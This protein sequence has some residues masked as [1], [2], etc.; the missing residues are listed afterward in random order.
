MMQSSSS[1]S[2]DYLSIDISEDAERNI[3]A[4]D[5]MWTS[6]GGI[7]RCDGFKLVEEDRKARNVYASTS[8][9]LPGGSPVLF[10]PEA[11]ILSSA[12]AMAEL[13]VLP[14]MEGA[15]R[16]ITDAGGGSE[17]R[18][19][20]LMLKVLYELQRGKGSP[21]YQWLNSLPRYYSNAPAMTD[22]CLLCLPPLMRKLVGEERENQRRLSDV[23][24]VPFLSD[25]I[26]NHPRDL[27]R[28]AYQVVYTRSVSVY[29]ESTGDYDLR[30]VPL[31]DYFN[32]GS[33][34]A[35]IDSRYDECGN[36]HATSSYDVPAGSP[37]RVRYA[38]PRNPSHLLA[39]YGFLD[40]TCPATYC[41]LLPPTVNRDMLD[42]GYSHDRMLFY[43]SGEVADEV[44]V[45]RGWG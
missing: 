42:L 11:L 26:K 31:A 17:Y 36:Y 9:D 22:Y 27:A 5:L 7:L 16:R 14:D 35:E 43:R 10:V 13:R 45:C 21:W 1:S 34:Y 15:E 40:E 18:Q 44:S 39:R 12:K 19:Y 25:D 29:D 38:D 37:L 41:K 4:F 6:G 28:W 20:Y 33:E 24:L 3:M 32:H 8:I 2:L 23:S 30:I